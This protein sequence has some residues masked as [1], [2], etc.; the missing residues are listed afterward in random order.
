MELPDHRAPKMKDVP[1]SAY[2]KVCWQAVYSLWIDKEPHDGSCIEGA[3][4]IEDCNQAMEWERFRGRIRK[5]VSE[6]E[7]EK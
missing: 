2:C 4:R 5:Y 6:T 1:Y 7:A 3:C